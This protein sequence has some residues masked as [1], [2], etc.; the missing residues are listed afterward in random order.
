MCIQLL[1]LL[2][3]IFCIPTLQGATLHSIIFV[4]TKTPLLKES[5]CADYKILCDEISTVAK[6]TG[7]EL[8]E[9]H[10][11][12]D[13]NDAKRLVSRLKNLKTSSDDVIL[14][15]FSGNG[16]HRRGDT[17]PWPTL[18]FCQGNRSLKLSTVISY[19]ETKDAR[20]KLIFSDCCNRVTD[21]VY[22]PDLIEKHPY[23]SAMVKS[24]YERLFL[25]AHGQIV[26][27]SSKEGEYSLSNTSGG[28]FT[29]SLIASLKNETESLDSEASWE[30]ILELVN[31]SVEN[32]LDDYPIKQHPIYALEL[33]Y[34]DE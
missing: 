34:S 18:E 30:R 10:F 13:R 19:L 31:Q 32:E 16:H 3:I 25:K 26:A 2:S 15:L 9:W 21:D 33:Y 5:T 23:L 1:I 6:Q 7:L 8:K 4:D 22:V 17:T 29:K 14:F 20:L 11:F 28:L 12:G 27:V 24:N